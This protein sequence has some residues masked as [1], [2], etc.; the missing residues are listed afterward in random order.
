LRREFRMLT[1]YV[2]LQSSYMEGTLYTISYMVNVGM[3]NRYVI[4]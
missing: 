4:L 3:N 1:K 2:I